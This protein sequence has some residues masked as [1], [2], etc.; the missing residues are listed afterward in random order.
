VNR[1]TR[2]SSTLRTTNRWEGDATM[3]IVFGILLAM[4]AAFAVT[5][6]A[7]QVYPWC[8][9]YGF[10]DGGTNCGFSTLQQCQWAISGNGGFCQANPFYRPSYRPRRH[11]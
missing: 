4:T 5:P 1:R 3:K 10:R 2:S 6:A 9:H 11:R 8:A 7:A